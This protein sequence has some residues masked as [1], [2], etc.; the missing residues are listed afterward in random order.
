MTKTDT[1]IAEAIEQEFDFGTID[2]GDQL[3][4]DE[5]DTIKPVEEPALNGFITKILELRRFIV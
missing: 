1:K 3:D 2:I 5:L 4:T